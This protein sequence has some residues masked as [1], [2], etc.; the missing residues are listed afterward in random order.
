M[1][2]KIK[3]EE[4]NMPRM[5]SV[6]TRAVRSG[7]S[8][9]EEKGDNLHLSPADGMRTL[10]FGA[11][12]AIVS[13]ALFTPSYA[14]A[15]E[16]E[17][18]ADLRRML[19]E[20]QAQN[21]VLSRRLGALE[22]A[23][24]VAAAQPT[25]H[26][27]AQRTKPATST[28][29]KSAP[30]LEQPGE[31]A[32]LPEPRD[33]TKLGLEQRVKALETG[34][35]AQEDAT[36]QIIGD[37][38]SKTGSKINSVLA[39]SGAIEV[40]ASRSRDFNGSTTDKLVLSTAELD[41][42]IKLSD[43]LKGS[44]VLGYESGTS[45]ISP[46]TTVTTPGVERVTIDR[47]HVLIGDVTRFPISARVG[48]EVLPFGTSTGVARL[49]TLS[50]NT[51]LTTEVFENRQTTAGLEF[52]LPTPPLKP[53]PPAVVIPRVRPLV[54]APLADSFMRGLGYKPLPQ[55][56]FPPAP[57]RPP[58]NLP[59]FYGSFMVYKGSETVMPGE[60]RLQDFNASLGYRTSGDCGR[61][62]EAL[63]SSLVCPWQIDFHVDYNS[64]VFNSKFLEAS[65][66]PFLNQIGRVPGVAASAK[67]SFGPFA[68]VGEINTAT[69][70]VRFL[71]AL[72]TLNNI[73]PMTWQVSVAYQFDWN[74][75]VVEIGQQGT[76]VSVAYSGSK[77]MAGVTDLVNGVPT[78]IGFVPR[79]RLSVTGG[80]W[81][82][83]GL[84]LAVEY[85]AN[86]DYSQTAGGTGQVTHGALGSVQLN[87]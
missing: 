1:N 46:T 36:R 49:D 72:G 2:M 56:V 77:D 38:L 34:R 57:V 4:M 75:W 15:A 52:A 7:G 53:L 59:P 29:A 6:E 25:E 69:R 62:Y 23:Q 16:S 86:W 80:E 30:E 21:R 60:T 41:F 14:V 19:R 18:K 24:A 20:L 17:E 12:L 13:L 9:G 54:V 76:Y 58:V 85:S 74:P 48:R 8:D 45:P 11:A 40:K 81:V 67:G 42:D 79:H 63:Q 66:R 28:A 64:S 78:R 31:A 35:A 37:S 87:F 70:D 44:L 82:M 39:L 73:T 51:P 83:D 84:R 50:I 47:A 43:W 55:R 26:A 10:F 27:R 71:D 33:T 68:L 3:Y 61:P 65:Y 22:R 32:R 5:I